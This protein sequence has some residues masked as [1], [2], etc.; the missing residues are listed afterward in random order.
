VDASKGFAECLLARISSATG[1]GRYAWFEA[2]NCG[3]GVAVIDAAVMGKGEAGDDGDGEEIGVDENDV[4]ED[5]R[6]GGQDHCDEAGDVELCAASG[7]EGD[8]LEGI[9]GT[10]GSGSPSVA[11]IMSSS[12]EGKKLRNRASAC[13]LLAFLNSTQTSIRPGRE[14]AGSR[15]SR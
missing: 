3:S 5:E 2:P 1:G 7:G 14:R 8:G 11:S 12:A 10:T 15:R 6:D 9:W 4:A 13:H